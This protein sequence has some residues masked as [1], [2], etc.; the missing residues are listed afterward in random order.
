MTKYNVGDLLLFTEHPYMDTYQ[1]GIIIAIN[2]NAYMPYTVKWIDGVEHTF[3]SH[4][5]GREIRRFKMNYNRF[6]K[7][8]K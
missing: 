1:F 6:F 3:A 7:R 5:S 8:L 4:F 2:E